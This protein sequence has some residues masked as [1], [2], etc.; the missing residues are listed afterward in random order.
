M[1]IYYRDFIIRPWEEGDRWIAAQVIQEVLA[2]YNLRWEPD[3]AD[4]EVLAV[5]QF[6]LQTQGEFWVIEQNNQIVGTSGYYPINRDDFP[7]KAAEIRKM[8]LLPSARGQGLGR[9]LLQSLESAIASQG[10]EII[11]IKTATIRK[12]AISLYESSGYQ[13]IDGTTT[14][15]CDRTYFK[16]LKTYNKL[17]LRPGQRH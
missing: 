16:I 15:R 3:D 10:C 7:G 9:F 11:W 5:E 6:Y 1:P 2:E 8:Y 12:E 17:F 14:S 4:R 13:L